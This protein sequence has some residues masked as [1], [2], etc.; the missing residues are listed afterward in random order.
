MPYI[1]LVE[2]RIEPGQ[3]D[4]FLFSVNENAN[5][6][7][8]DEDGCVRFD[9]LVPVG[10]ESKVI[11]YEIYSSL[12]A[13]EIHKVSP[14]VRKFETATRTLVLDKRVTELALR[15]ETSAALGR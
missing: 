6:S 14:H 2:F 4:E 3:L 10:D 5:R 7:V 9:V 11:L 12:E 8:T 15:S 1:I 13:F